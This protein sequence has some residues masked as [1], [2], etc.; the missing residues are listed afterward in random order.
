MFLYFS[1]SSSLAFEKEV[2]VA[3]RDMGRFCRYDKKNDAVRWE[4]LQDWLQKKAGNF[5]PGFFC[6]LPSRNLFLH[7]VYFY[8]A[9]NHPSMSSSKKRK[10][11][12]DADTDTDPA[13]GFAM[14]A[15]KNRG[16]KTRVP[17][18]PEPLPPD[19][20]PLVPAFFND[21]QKHAFLMA[22]EVLMSLQIIAKAGVGKTTFF[23]HLARAVLE[24]FKDSHV[25]LLTYNT[26]LKKQVKKNADEIVKCDRLLVQ[27]Y[28]GLAYGFLKAIN[29]KG[30]MEPD[31]NL[32]RDAIK[33]M[34]A[35]ASVFEKK[36]HQIRYL[37]LDEC[38][39]I[40]ALHAEFLQLIYQT[41]RSGQRR[42]NQDPCLV[43][44]V[45]GDPLQNLYAS[46]SVD[47]LETPNKYF[48]FHTFERLD[49]PAPYRMSLSSWNFIMTHLNV[50]LIDPDKLYACVKT[51]FSKPE[52]LDKMARLRKWW[53]NGFDKPTNYKPHPRNPKPGAT[54]VL[55]CESKNWETRLPGLLA[56]YKRLVDTYGAANVIVLASNVTENSPARHFINA[57]TQN[58]GWKWQVVDR[59]NKDEVGGAG[60]AMG[61]GKDET[62]EPIHRLATIQQS[63]GMEYD[64]GIVIGF[65]SYNLLPG[66]PLH[67]EFFDMFYQLYVALT[68]F[69]HEVVP[70]VCASGK[71]CIFPTF[72]QGE[73]AAVKDV[74]AAHMIVSDDIVEIKSLLAS[75]KDNKEFPRQRHQSPPFS[76]SS[77]SSSSL[78]AAD[79][80]TAAPEAPTGF[81]SVTWLLKY[82]GTASDDVFDGHESCLRVQEIPHPEHHPVKTVKLNLLTLT[83]ENK[84]LFPEMTRIYGR[85]VST[86]LEIIQSYVMDQSV[87]L[88]D[89]LQT[90]KRLAQDNKWEET[91]STTREVW[92]EIQTFVNTAWKKHV[93]EKGREISWLTVL[94]ATVILDC[95]QTCDIRCWKAMYRD[96]E[97]W[98]D[99][100][101][102]ESCL[103]NTLHVLPESGTKRH[104]YAISKIPVLS[105]YSELLALVKHNAFVGLSGRVDLICNDV[106]YEIK[107]TSAMKQEHAFQAMLY[108]SLIA[109]KRMLKME[110]VKPLDD[111]TVQDEANVVLAPVGRVFNVEFSDKWRQRI[112]DLLNETRP[113]F[114]RLQRNR[115]LPILHHLMFLILMM[116][117]R[118]GVDVSLKSVQV[119]AMNQSL[120]SIEMFDEEMRKRQEARE[121]M[122]AFKNQHAKNKMQ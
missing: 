55:Y 118:M 58:H 36:L 14:E 32:I 104:E 39:D 48:P 37:M 77:S 29:F 52:F 78:S 67:I 120:M 11:S 34:K 40:S 85:C 57:S 93:K 115:A 13:W 87:Y 60:G 106:V 61:A 95:L 10:P 24:M 22:L 59:N 38:P 56:E 73:T 110:V 53:G 90:I 19:E 17:D 112:E 23:L 47:L 46:K 27:N 101:Y 28:H 62:Q 100:N 6:F 31:D 70:V 76:S 75:T 45:C 18:S 42:Y 20:H 7:Q 74:A 64:A 105:R 109:T 44:I 4:S 96:F 21:Y 83:D 117:R 89:A 103:R 86:R 102:L 2:E 3:F 81:R 80:A 65:D 119:K 54:R 111:F 25:L 116:M 30:P 92:G 79:P 41:I 43:V 33:A 98:L 97:S 50:A 63:K 122:N 68:R 88:I 5:F 26:R 71:N 82:S 12:R 15:P 99:E 91:S 51:S 108:V 35:N 121:K 16:R 72:A 8:H 113:R 84:H 9:Q 1:S 114:T 66:S 49:F 94:Q 69:R 107:A